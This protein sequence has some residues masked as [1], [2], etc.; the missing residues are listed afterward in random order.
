MTPPIAQGHRHVAHPCTLD[1]VVLKAGD[2]IT[3]TFYVYQ[4]SYI[5][6]EVKSA[7]AVNGEPS[8]MAVFAT[9]GGPFG[10]DRC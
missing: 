9:A 5:V 4:V 6:V 10:V 2:A 1:G 7:A 8:P 3:A